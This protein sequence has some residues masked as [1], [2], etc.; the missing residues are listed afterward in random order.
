MPR[1]IL[2]L[3]LIVVVMGAITFG[4]TNAFFSDTETSVANVF[5]AGAID[6]KVDNESYYNGVFNARTSWS[7]ADLNDGNGPSTGGTYKFFDFDDLKPADYGED[8]ISLHVDTNDAFMCANVTLTS[9]D[10]NTQTEPE[11][12]VDSNGL[13]TGELADLVNFIW[14]ADDGDNVLEDDENVISQGPI[15]ALP[16]NSPYELAL[17]DADE[18]VWGG[19]GPVDGDVT[20]Y[21]GKAWCFGTIGGAP[22]NQDGLT[23]AMSPADDN[24]DNLTA[25]EPEDGG[26]SCNGAALGNESQT[27]S[28]TADIEFTVV[29]SR[30]NPGFQCE[31]NCVISEEVTLIPDSG[32]ENPEVTN[33]A[34]WDIFASPAGAWNVAWR[35][36]IPATFGS[37]NRPA[38]AS[39]EIHEGV[40]GTPFEGDQY[41]ELDSDWAGP[42]GTGDGEPAS[43]IIYQDIPTV[44]GKEYRIEFQFAAR[45]NTDASENRLETRWG[46]VVVNDTGFVGD[47]NAGIDWQEISIDVVA[48]SALT[49]LQFTDLGTANSIGTFVDNFRLYT[50]SCN[51]PE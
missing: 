17:A 4:A 50:E 2:S 9:D 27:D 34:G 11:A 16:L 28:L 23:D 7:Q 18:N 38:I 48:T 3:A 24:N 46:G 14:W 29:Q 47:V 33:G 26:I 13:A 30:N 1:I 44:I 19:V 39:L 12:E 31:E 51:L 15:G 36:D 35:G 8:T 49:R 5:T 25:G 37:Q 32:F 45:P 10:D 20:Y 41:A 40:V 6:L 22:I 42:D 21:L 43:V